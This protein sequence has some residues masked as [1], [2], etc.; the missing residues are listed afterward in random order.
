MPE[1]NKSHVERICFLVSSSSSAA[2]ATMLK[3]ATGW[4]TKVV[5][6]CNHS[7]ITQ[8]KFCLLL[9]LVPLLLQ[10]GFHF[11]HVL[12]SSAP[13]RQA[14]SLFDLR[15]GRPNE[16]VLQQGEVLAIEAQIDENWSVLLCHLCSRV[17]VSGH[18]CSGRT[19]H[20]SHLLRPCRGS[21]SITSSILHSHTPNFY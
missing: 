12:S 13:Q 16:L 2:S 20:L 19:R 18:E 1:I 3:I 17:Q 8:R 10:Y 9:S 11:S 14:I 5:P 15:S 4:K 7:M 6:I 21:A